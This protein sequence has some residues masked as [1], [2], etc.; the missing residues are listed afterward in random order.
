MTDQEIFD[1]AKA[2]DSIGH[3]QKEI[4]RFIYVEAKGPNDLSD[5]MFY[6]SG[7]KLISLSHKSVY[8]SFSNWSPADRT[9]WSEKYYNGRTLEGPWGA[10]LE[11][12]Q[13]LKA[14][15][16]HLDLI[17][18]ESTEHTSYHRMDD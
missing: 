18:R 5:L 15:L 3:Q 12:I 2:L 16:P 8:S 10:V 4:I 6:F 13:N 7:R 1:L 14:E 17:I 11:E 9:G